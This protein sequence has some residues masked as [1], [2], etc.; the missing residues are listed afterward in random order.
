MGGWGIKERR[1]RCANCQV[2]NSHGDVKYS[3]GKVNT[4]VITMCGV[5][6]VLELLG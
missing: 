3:T 4:I 2:K 5:R 1:L 6:S